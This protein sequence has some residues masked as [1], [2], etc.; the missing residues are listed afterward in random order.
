MAL[1]PKQEAFAQAYQGSKSF[2]QAVAETGAIH[3]T[4]CGYY[5]YFLIDPTN[6]EI[7]YVG[8]GK[9]NRVA[10]HVKQAINGNIANA[11][12]HKRITNVISAGERVQEFIFEHY[13]V[14][15]DAFACEK[16][17]I[18]AI[19]YLGITNIAN[20]VMTNDE[21]VSEEA[22]FLLTQLAPVS[23]LNSHGKPEM[24]E[25]IEARFGS[26]EA[27]GDFLRVALNKLIIPS[28]VDESRD[29]V[30]GQ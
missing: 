8:K 20:G 24:R 1:T 25:V 22:K 3:S 21:K 14:E 4:G 2:S 15:R 19:R 11:E 7:F 10:S 30:Y 5:V 12:K 18:E 6:Q 13:D 29:A 9:G 28:K 17:F 16:F 27:Y 23:W 26:F